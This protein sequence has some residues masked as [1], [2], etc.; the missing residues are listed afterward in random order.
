MRGYDVVSISEIPERGISDEDF[1]A[2]ALREEAVLVTRDYHFTNPVRFSAEKTTGIIY[3]RHGNLKS[4]EEIRLVED[5]LQAH[6]LELF[7]GKLV[8]LYLNSVRIR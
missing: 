8:T 5:F 3:I 6:D 7:R 1:Y 2:L 4:E